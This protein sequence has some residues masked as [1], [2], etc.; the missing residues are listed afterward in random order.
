MTLEITLLGRPQIKIGGQVAPAINANKA[1]ALLYYLATT[2][3]TH[4]RQALAGLLW[5]DLPEEA[6]RRN[7]R[8]ELNRLTTVFD[9]YLLRNRET[10]AFNRDLPHWL[11]LALFEAILKHPDPTTEQLRAAVDL[12]QG[13]FLEDFHVRDAA[14]FEEWQHSQREHLHQAAQR[15]TMRLVQRYGQAGEYDAAISYAQRL[16]AREP[17]LEEGHQQLMVLYARTGQRGAALAQYELCCQALDSEY[18]VPPS[19]ETNAIY[20]RILAGEIAAESGVEMLPGVVLTPPRPTAPPFQAP[21]PLLHFVGREDEL[22]GL[23]TAIAQETDSPI[24]AVVG[25]GGV[26]KSTIAAHLAHALKEDFPDGV[27]WAHVAT[28]DPLDVLSQ[29]ARAFGYDFSSLADVENRAAALR[30]VLAEK[31]VLLVLDDV[32]SVARTRPLL[33]GGPRCATLLTT[34]DLDVANALNARPHRLSELT[35]AA[36]LRLLTRILGEERVSA[37]PEAAQ[38]LCALLQYLPLAVEITAQ[39]LVSR[40]RRRLADMADRLR[41]VEERLDL[42]ISDRAV[43]TSFQVSWEALDAN[44][45]RIFSLLGVFEGRSFAA[46]AVAHLA[47]LDRY[48]AEDRL[49]ALTALSLV[50]EET[51]DRYRQHPL[52]ADFAVEQLGEN[53]IPFVDMA[54]YY[55]QFAEQN[56][57]NYAALRPEWENLMAG[58]ET[59]HRLQQW[60]LVL[61]YAESL[62]QAWF[63][64]ARYTQARRGYE[65]AIDAAESLADERVWAESLLNLARACLEQNDYPE[66]Q[67]L[68]GE[69][70]LKF[71]S[72][73]NR[74]K[75]AEARYYLGRIA[76]EQAEYEAADR[77]LTSSLQLQEQLQDPIAAAATLYQEAFLAYRRNE[78][79]QARVLCMRALALQEQAGNDAGIIP[80]LRLLADIAVEQKDYPAA[81][82]Y[83]N[84]SLSLCH[85]LHDRGE[86]AATCYSLAVVARFQEKLDM[87][88]QYAENALELSKWMGNR[89]FQAMAWYEQFWIFVKRNN[90]DAA[91]TVGLKSLE[92]FQ[93]LQDSFNLVYVLCHLGEFYSANEQTEQ[94]TALWRQALALASR[95]NHPLAERLQRNLGET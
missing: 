5:S 42:S 79:E 56:R 88:Q 70:L 11:D 19:D 31:R 2:G 64:R 6:A 3:Q 50:G 16:L 90:I 68:L 12:Y 76:I 47:G 95:I 21:A 15:L 51:T 77:L 52:L 57:T 85:Q 61:N 72:L 74:A 32:R 66:A 36:S 49:F 24:V 62:T 28:S 38:T 30:G 86:L 22:A 59:A 44:L 41:H 69:S 9:P 60:P 58:M 87:A 4:S 40:P 25:M 71:E 78:F 37:E 33:A 10:L 54:L 39:R 34:R 14:L 89:Q 55:Q 73:D 93:E 48:T 20:D 65:W 46:D 13:E 81:E 75:M 17:W 53:Q 43:R 45:R 7:L 67:R 63:T 84:R 92:L 29:W 80:I 91:A 26:G 23:R 8:V 35:P 94:A 27:L 82:T 18:G 1:L 83:L